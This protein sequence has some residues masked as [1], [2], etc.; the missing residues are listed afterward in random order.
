MPR[1]PTSSSNAW[2]GWP[3]TC[4]RTVGP[5]SPPAPGRPRDR[6]P[7]K[8][9]R[10][11][12]RP[13]TT[14]STPSCGP[15][16]RPATL[17]EVVPTAATSVH[18]H[19]RAAPPVVGRRSGPAHRPPAVGRRR[20]GG[21]G[22]PP[23]GGPRLRL[24]GQAGRHGEV[25]AGAT[26]GDNGVRADPTVTGRAPTGRVKWG[27]MDDPGGLRYRTAA[28][29]WVIAATVLGSGMASIDA[30]VVGIAVPP[31]AGSSTRRWPSSSGWSTAT[32]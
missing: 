1:S 10:S 7:S 3:G 25:P 24:T 29:R 19:G 30:T 2:P 4:R 20:P 11:A 17:A 21:R 22:A 13:V 8:A 15:A 23:R 31:S 26:T 9:I 12:T 5:S 6:P 16:G 32:P 18:R 27:P 14:R 28:G